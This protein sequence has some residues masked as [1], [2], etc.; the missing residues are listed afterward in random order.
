MATEPGA[1]PTAP[2]Q[3]A[4]TRLSRLLAAGAGVAV[5]GTLVAASISYVH[6]RAASL[7]SSY[8]SFCN[9]G[10]TFNCDA[11]LTSPFATLGN[12]PVAWLAL[13]TYAAMA[14]LFWQ[15][16]QRTGA[17][18]RA[19]FRLVSASVAFA[20]VFSVYMAS[21]SLLVLG[22]VCLQC[23]VLYLVCL[24]LVGIVLYAARLFTTAWPSVPRPLDSSS[25]LACLAAAVAAVSVLAAAT[26]PSPARMPPSLVSLAELRE[27][28]P[29]FYK[30]YTGL[31]INRSDAATSRTGHG[32]G[33]KTAP[34]AIVEYSDLQ[35]EHCRKNH[36]ILKDLLARRPKEVRVIYRHF[37]LD[38]SCNEAVP[39]T[40]HRQACRAAEAA[41][42][43]A[44]Q[45]RFAEMI[46]QIFDNQ[47]QLFEAKL[48]KMA[49]SIGL[50]Q[51]EFEA[52]LKGRQA[53][54][55]VVADSQAGAR[56]HLTSTP[57]LFIN[58]RKVRGAF[59]Q[60]PDYDYAVLIEAR[61]LAGDLAP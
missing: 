48:L 9:L 22:A 45:G 8:T 60:A 54:S 53:L 18:A 19:P 52:C 7:G 24:L 30:W 32:L 6:A 25:V 36:I 33:A 42:C 27:S 46:D 56:L 12:I 59:E 13:G 2:I 41:E 61:L 14:L 38:E 49:A 37:P 17:R 47:S 57:T 21:V 3:L 16:S 44:R 39:R 1:S 35:C 55:Q 5:L 34:V 40:I 20:V 29:D 4:R 11:V 26:W 43:A 31:P 28:R 15:A 51:A 10:D 58:G 23:T 50:D